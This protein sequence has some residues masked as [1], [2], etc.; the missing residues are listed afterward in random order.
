MLSIPSRD[1][2]DKAMLNFILQLNPVALIHA[3][4]RQSA[5]LSHQP[6]YSLL[7]EA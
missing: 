3:G 2:F 1:E 7:P 6:M 4:I 5:R